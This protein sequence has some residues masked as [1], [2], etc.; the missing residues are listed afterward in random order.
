MKGNPPLKL[1]EVVRAIIADMVPIGTIMAYGG[2]VRKQEIIDQLGN[3]GWLVCNGNQLKRNEHPELFKTI[4]GSFGAGDGKTS[5]HLPDMRGQ[6][7]RG[8]DHNRGM[9]RDARSRSPAAPGGNRGD[10]VGSVQDDQFKEHKHPLSVLPP[11]MCNVRA[12][13]YSGG[14]HGK[15]YNFPQSTGMQGGSETRPKNIYV[16]WI[17][18][19]KHIIR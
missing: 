9:D 16:N 10:A 13:P 12:G 2:D 7:L 8:V 14:N 15:Y 4:G 18:K 17:I 5:F 6:F 3:E 11:V 1:E 19:A